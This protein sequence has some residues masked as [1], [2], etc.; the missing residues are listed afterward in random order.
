MW[1]AFDPESAARRG[2]DGELSV[3]DA[4]QPPDDFDP[5]RRGAVVLIDEI[6]KAEPDVP[7]SLLVP[8]GEM[9]FDVIDLGIRV[10]SATATWPIVVLTSNQ[11]RDLSPAFERR[12]V[13]IELS[14]PSNG[15]LRA[16]G[17]SHFDGWEALEQAM[18]EVLARVQPKDEPSNVRRVVP[19]TFVDLL[20][21][22]RGGG[23][24]PGSEAWSQLL[25]LLGLEGSRHP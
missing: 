23:I 17:R 5:A 3:E 12:C 6:D 19:A 4:P 13:R 21:A 24:S 7:N 18:D 20:R 1:W 9:A 10:S 2:G 22:V 15:D 14:L 8:L 25:V 16:I 11:E